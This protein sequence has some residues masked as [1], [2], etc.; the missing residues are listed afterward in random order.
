MSDMGP[1]RGLVMIFI[2][3]FVLVVVV[4][5]AI[6]VGLFAMVQKAFARDADG[7]SQRLTPEQRLWAS[8]LRNKAGALCCDDADGYDPTWRPA[9]SSPSG[10][11]VMLGGELDG[12]F[13]RSTHHGAEQAGCRAGVGHVQG[14]PAGVALLRPRRRR[15]K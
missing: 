12:C 2:S 9:I 13:R 3:T 4:V 1:P 8:T 5:I 7:L 11:Q 6:L 14:R 10:Y 15:V